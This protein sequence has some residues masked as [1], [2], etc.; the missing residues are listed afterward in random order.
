MKIGLMLNLRK[1]RKKKGMT[2]KEVSAAV[3]ISMSHLSQVERGL[4]NPSPERLDKLREF[5][6]IPFVRSETN[7]LVYCIDENRLCLIASAL[8]SIANPS[9]P[10]SPDQLQMARSV[11]EQQIESANNALEVLGERFPELIGGSK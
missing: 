11:I 4:L 8:K 9:V 3:G 1:I 6:Q 10:Y 7:E 5:Y 2:L